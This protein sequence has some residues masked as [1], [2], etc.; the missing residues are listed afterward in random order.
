M[1]D[2]AD[3]FDPT[4]EVEGAEAPVPADAEPEAEDLEVTIDGEAPSQD[5]DASDADDAEQ[6]PAEAPKW[7]K[8]T[9]AKN[10]EMARRV[11]EL[12]AQLAQVPK[13]PEPVAVA[14]GDKPTWPNEEFDPEKFGADLEAWNARKAIHDQTVATAKKSAEDDRALWQNRITD[15]DA[16]GAKYRAYPQAKAALI[17][18]LSQDQQ[19][20]IVDAANDPSLVVAAL[21]LNPSKA[22]ALADIKNPAKFCAEIA[23]LELKMNATPRAPQ[24]KP[25][26]VISGT[27]RS[28]TSTN[29]NLTRLQ[30]KAAETGDYSA[31]FAAKRGQSGK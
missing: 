31:Y 6:D 12:E 9:R 21:G 27:G 13:A 11:K 19:S 14:L 18:I 2:L 10:R 22:K 5:D 8:D 23:R 29:A 7:V 1:N 16:K 24:T 28:P 3:D 20:M 4:D 17:T 30:E 26:R 25:D 15:M